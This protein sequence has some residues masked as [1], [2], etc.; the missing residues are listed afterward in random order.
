M[1]GDGYPYTVNRPQVIWGTKRDGRSA[2]D[3]TRG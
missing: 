2:T 3:A 1:P